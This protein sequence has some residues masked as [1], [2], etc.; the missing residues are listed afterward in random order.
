M[1]VRQK[2]IVGAGLALPMRGHASRF[3]RCHPERSEGSRRGIRLGGAEPGL[4][5][6]ICGI[7]RIFA[8]HARFFQ[9]PIVRLRGRVFSPF[10]ECGGSTPLC[11]KTKMPRGAAFAPVVDSRAASASGGRGFNRD[12][13]NRLRN[14]FLLRVSSAQSGR[15]FHSLE[16]ASA[17]LAIF[18][19]ALTFFVSPAAFAQNA[20]TPN[21][22]ANNSPA[23]SAPL[24]AAWANWKYS[25]RI[26]LP[27]APPSG[28][29]ERLVKLRL[30]AE[31]FA[32]AQPNLADLRI[33][34]DL[35]AQT[36]YLLRV[37]YAARKTQMRT[38]HQLEL[39]WLPGKYTQI[40]VDTGKTP[41]VHN[42]VSLFAPRSDFMA[43]AQ[44][45]V[46]DNARTW[47]HTSPLEPIYRFGSRGVYGSQLVTYPETN[48]RYIRVR[49]YGKEKFFTRATMQGQ[50]QMP[51]GQIQTFTGPL[52][53]VEYI[54]NVKGENV[55]L[56]AHFA[57]LAGSHP[58][59]SMWTAKLP[60]N[61]PANSVR[62]ECDEHEFSREVK[63]DSS[64]DGENWIQ[65]A[66]G[67]IYRLQAIPP[68]PDSAP[69]PHPGSRDY[70]NAGLALSESFGP[71]W[72]VEIENG[73]DAPLANASIELSMAAR[74]VFFREEPGRSYSLIFGQS[75]LH[76]EPSY[77]LARTLTD[78]Q[79]NSAFAAPGQVTLGPERANSAWQDPRPWTERHSLV[80]WLAVVLAAI[81]LT[82]LA[83][84]SLKGSHAPNTPSPPADAAM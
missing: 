41:V 52:A 53:Y 32:H 15:L 69:D 47:R 79:M 6:R 45:E 12:I 36:P 11:R 43:W 61:V 80:L 60:F 39:S 75:Q 5:L 78:A 25:R 50:F 18:I 22:A 20:A 10:S 40:V 38:G 35:G 3:L 28:Q 56:D 65:Q 62:I 81:A 19:L 1:T 54:T 9:S 58:E 4:L 23:S 34:D 63:V 67:R 37:E 27:S 64:A 76:A 59:K 83:I 44:V 33:I 70:E 16:L 66:S 77:D 51:D 26:D 48:A 14:F 82:F 30:P 17:I 29:T 71:Y 57:K 21:P 72:R 84:Q 73:N 7:S 8:S 24:P 68:F 46:S 42:A 31:V 55:P 74:D 13:N 2:S 49:I